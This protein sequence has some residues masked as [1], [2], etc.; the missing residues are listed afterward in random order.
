MPQTWA[1]C[2]AGAQSRCGG[3]RAMRF[4]TTTRTRSRPSHCRV[5]KTLLL[6]H[7]V[8]TRAGR[9]AHKDGVRMTLEE[10]G[11]VLRGGERA[12]ADHDEEVAA[13]V[14]LLAAHD[15]MQEWLC[16]QR[17]AAVVPAQVQDQFVD[18]VLIDVL[19]QP[20]T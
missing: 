9:F 11:Q 4:A 8:W 10:R 3:P 15:L 12:S 19:D 1:A 13:A 18:I 14:D 6:A 5:G 17:V 2:R 7:N 16:Q 20:F